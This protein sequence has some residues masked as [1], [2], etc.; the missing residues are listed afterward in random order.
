MPWCPR[1]AT[2]I[3]QHEIVTDGYAELT[4]D[5]ITLRFPLRGRDHEYL[6]VWTT[7]PWT[8]TSNVAAAVGPD[9]TYVKVRQGEDILYLSRGTLHMLNGPYQVLAEL[10]G[11][12]MVG[13]TYDGPFDDLPAEQEPGGHTTL[14]KLVRGVAIS[15][16]QVHQVILWD[17]VGETEGTGIVHIAPGCGAEDFELGR[18]H[19]FP[20]VAPLEEEGHFVEGFGWLTGRHVSEVAPL[21]F[22]DLQRKGLVYQIAP[23]THRYPTCWR[24]KTELVF[25]L[26]DEW[27][28]SMG[29][30]YDKPREEL[31]VEEK[32]S[33]LRYQIMDVVGQIKWIPEFGY[34]RE[35]DWLRN[36]HDWMISKK[37]YWGLALPI[38]VCMTCGHFEVIGD[39]VELKQASG[40]GMGCLRGAYASPALHRCGE[41]GL[42]GVPG[43]DGACPGGRQSLVGCRDRVVQHAAIPDQ[44]RFLALLVPGPLDQ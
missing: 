33:S 35:M 19:K 31:T 17:A 2:A 32:A 38:W 26:V 43:R 1:C 5:S 15:A 3:S 29:Q 10:K 44:S 36:M 37:R 25:R 18:E 28:I 6:L 21:I 7:T 23:Y 12:D 27:F 20:L 40:E 13:W 9:L 39:E 16:A 11:T 8:L 41:V 30:V 4:H 42:F 22:A 34:S 14:R 24:C